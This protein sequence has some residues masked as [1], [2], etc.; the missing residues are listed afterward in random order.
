ML[1][2]WGKK[3]EKHPE[4]PRKSGVF[5]GRAAENKGF[6]S[7][8]ATGASWLACPKIFPMYTKVLC[9]VYAL[10]F[11]VLLTSC[12]NLEHINSFAT[13]SVSSLQ[14]QSSNY[15]YGQSC[16][17]FDCRNGVYY[18]PDTASDLYKAF[19]DTSSCDCDAF[20][21]ADQALAV[22]NQV[23]SAYLTG[24]GKLSD[25]KAVNYNF[26]G[27]VGAIDSN[28]L[29]KSKLS[30]TS[31]Q[32]TSVGKIATIL[33]NDMM[34]VYRKNR[35]KA[36]IQKADP[37][38]QIV[39]AAY[40]KEMKRFQKIILGDDVKWLQNKYSDFFQ[41]NVTIRAPRVSPYEAALVYQ[42]YLNDKAKILA[43]SQM[44]DPFIAALQKVQA[45][46]AELAKEF[47]HLTRDD[48]KQAING[49]SADIS[50]LVQDYNSFKKTT[51]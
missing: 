6:F 8:V 48:V 2:R 44:T 7:C 4:K 47:D 51:K 25:S 12:V 40:I 21:K 36:I 42:D 39:L 34:N 45:G 17:D 29:A 1:W 26:T 16:L 27:L 49:Y 18:Y 3:P 43:Y 30:I 35:L 23:V 46:H 38:L 32:W 10:G 22:L 5:P 28:S 13:A 24:L 31:A 11:A 19:Y 50:S 14:A 37:D 33:A 9:R 20:K 15:S 41:K